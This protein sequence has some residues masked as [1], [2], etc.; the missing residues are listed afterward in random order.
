DYWAEV[1]SLRRDLLFCQLGTT[2]LPLTFDLDFP[3]S[4]T[5]PPSLPH[6]PQPLV[7]TTSAPTLYSSHSASVPIKEN[8]S[9]SESSPVDDSSTPTKSDHTTTASVFIPKQVNVEVTVEAI[10]SNSANK[11]TL[12]ESISGN[13]TSSITKPSSNSTTLSFHKFNT[14][15][16]HLMD[17]P[18]LESHKKATSHNKSL[19]QPTGKDVHQ[20]QVR[21]LPK[22][23]IKSSRNQI[24][25]IPNGHQAEPLARRTLWP[26]TRPPRSLDRVTSDEISSETDVLPVDKEYV[27]MLERQLR[28]LRSRVKACRSCLTPPQ[29]TMATCGGGT[30]WRDHRKRER[31]LRNKQ[32]SQRKERRRRV[33]ALQGIRNTTTAFPTPTTTTSST[34]TPKADT[35]QNP[36]QADVMSWFEEG[37]SSTDSK[38][39]NHRARQNHRM[40]T[41]FRRGFNQKIVRM[42]EALMKFTDTQAAFCKEL[43]DNLGGR[44]EKRGQELGAL[45]DQIAALVRTSTM[46]ISELE[47]VASAQLYSSQASIEKSLAVTQ[48]IR[49]SQIRA[50]QQYHKQT[51]L[52][53]AAAIATLL[54]DQASAVTSMGV[55]LITKVEMLQDIYV[56][57]ATQQY[58]TLQKITEDVDM[59]ASK[60]TNLVMRSRDHANHLHINAE[61]FIRELQTRMNNVV[62][63]LVLIRLQSQNFVSLNNNTHN[64]IFT[65]LN[66]TEIA[67]DMLSEGLKQRLLTAKEKE[68]DFRKTFK[69][70]TNQINDRL[71]N[72]I[73]QT[74]VSNHATMSHIEESELDTRV[75]V[76]TAV[77]AWDELYLNQ[78]AELRKEADSLSNSL[79]S[80]THHTQNI[81]GDLRSAAET[82]EQVLEEQRMDFQRFV[83]KRQ[84]ALDN[85][86]SAIT[87]WAMLMSSELRRRDEDLHKFLSEDLQYTTGN[88]PVR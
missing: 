37:P 87:D 41:D 71:E 36:L 79:R 62:K 68:H 48:A 18:P 51:F 63:E 67:V 19:L 27:A 14:Q 49:D 2:E 22:V 6:A 53:A 56:T 72:G 46:Q 40:S 64:D 20:G 73:S 32:R 75:F 69:L 16:T 10:P 3:S 39:N 43:R 88:V 21:G 25:Q 58:D 84:D 1:T 9:K 23:S 11:P 42:D 54:S 28:D 30:A 24:S 76:G 5:N 60:H 7:A 74:L 59:F 29:R 80:H 47:K 50:V 81:L 15:P 33:K 12:L 35:V 8:P 4:S 82:H 77:A 38:S 13:A 17:S 34:T 55:E 85:Q 45:S 61:T 65:S 31:Q 66:K 44:L 78:E 86:C 83:R 70:E 52:P 57:H 26:P